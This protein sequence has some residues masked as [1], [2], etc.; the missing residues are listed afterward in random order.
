METV[1]SLSLL[2]KN[3]NRIMSLVRRMKDFF[4]KTENA[5]LWGQ[6]VLLQHCSLYWYRKNHLHYK[7]TRVFYL[8]HC[9]LWPLSLGAE[10]A[11]EDRSNTFVI[12][13]LIY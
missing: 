4:N 6:A 9:F 10:S 5:D 8:I 11:H 3:Q 2:E 7:E 1:L 13:V 12:G